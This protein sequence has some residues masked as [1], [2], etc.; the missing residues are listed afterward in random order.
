MNITI[1]GTTVM[2]D[3]EIIGYFTYRTDTVIAVYD[4]RDNAGWVG[5]MKYQEMV[6]YFEGFET[7]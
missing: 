7:E 4:Y 3:E 6:D 2:Q 5:R 1:N